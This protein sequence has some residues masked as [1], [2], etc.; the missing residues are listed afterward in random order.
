MTP[1]KARPYRLHNLAA[2]EP[3][4]CRRIPARWYGSARTRASQLSK[5]GVGKFV[6]RLV[7]E[8][9]EVWRLS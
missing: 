6:T 8:T 2:L 5:R 3:G 9:V 7:G 1:P 4:K